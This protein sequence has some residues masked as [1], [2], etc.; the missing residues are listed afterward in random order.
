SAALYALASVIV[1][2]WVNVRGIRS[3]AGTQVW[4]TLAE[5]G[6]LLT[7]IVG[8]LF[9]ASQGLGNGGA[10]SAAPVEA[11]GAPGLAAFGMAMV[12]VL[13]TFGGWNEAA[14]I[15]AELKDERRNMV[16]AL[17]ISITLITVLYLLVNWAYL[18][19]LGH[20]GMAKSDAVAADLLRLAFGR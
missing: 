18:H 9:L 8:G 11:A 15:S 14:Y 5:V 17:V 16:R 19:G 10:A 4:L 12:F 7:V 6:G 1:L 3:G 13:L 2:T 20:A